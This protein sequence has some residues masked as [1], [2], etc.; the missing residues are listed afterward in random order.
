ME[1]ATR[2]PSPESATADK[3]SSAAVAPVAAAS[4]L[5]KPQDTILSEVKNA[6]T[7][8]ARRELAERMLKEARN[9]PPEA[10]P[11]ETP[12][13]EQPPAEPEATPESTEATSPETTETPETEATPETQLETEPTD[14]G[15][16]PTIPTAKQLRVT[17]PE[18]DKVGRLASSFL[19]RNRD[20]TMEQAMDAARNQLGIKPAEAKPETEPAKTTSDLPQDVAG[21]D[22]ALDALETEI[23]KA[24]DELRFTDAAK[25]AN[26]SRLLE[27][28]R[29]KLELDGEKQQVRAAAD[30]DQ[31]FR[32]SEAKAAELY[33]F[34]SKPDSAGAKRMLEIEAELQDL[35]DPLHYSPDKPLK[36]AQMVAAELNIAPR[37]KGT[38]AAPAKPAVP[39]VPPAKKNVLPTGASRTAP[40]TATPANTMNQEIAAAKTLGELRAVKKKYGFPES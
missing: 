15:N 10:P 38:P 14:D 8:A 21:V 26:K 6:N 20:W 36:I 35:D 37:R 39:A 5:Q 9:K 34:A 1:T 27:R 30:Y 19:R 29:M 12:A 7:P 11:Q 13:G 32:S 3:S 23:I 33:D 24:N 25:M 4:S 2:G 17:L 16:T 40:T 31:G 18:N 22:A 28:H